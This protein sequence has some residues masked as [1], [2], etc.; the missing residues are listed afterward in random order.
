MFVLVWLGM[1]HAFRREL[2]EMDRRLP[3]VRR[4][5]LW[6][7]GPKGSISAHLPLG[8]EARDALL[9]PVTRP[10]GVAAQG[11]RRGRAS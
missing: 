2:R 3:L 10:S 7:V 11:E 1:D 5:P 4:E 6:G 8:N 9:C